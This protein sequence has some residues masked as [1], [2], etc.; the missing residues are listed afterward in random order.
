MLQRE[1]WS[2]LTAF[3]GALWAHCVQS[4]RRK[5]VDSVYYHGTLQVS[6]HIFGDT[7]NYT[8]TSVSAYM[9][10]HMVPIATIKN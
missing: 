2:R 1:K 6:I 9:Q 7:Y 3:P 10:R 4:A 8:L 5:A